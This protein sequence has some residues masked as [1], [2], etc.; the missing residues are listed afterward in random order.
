MVRHIFKT[1]KIITTKRPM[2]HH[3][4]MKNDLNSCNYS[5]FFFMNIVIALRDIINLK[6]RIS[7]LM[8]S[9]IIQLSNV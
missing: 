7:F 5:L 3:H 4:N 9:K 8:K 2:G 1:E 6:N